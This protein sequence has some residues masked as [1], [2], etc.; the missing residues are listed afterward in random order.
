V[1]RQVFDLSPEFTGAH[2]YLALNL[3]AQRREA[4]A[5]AE[6]LCEAEAWARLL[7]LSIIHHASGHHVEADAA[8]R[9]LIARHAQDSAFQV[10][11]VYGARGETDAAF[12]WLERAYAQ[13]DPGLGS[14]KF[15]PLFR[16]LHADPRWSRFLRR[17]R[18]A[19]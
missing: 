19:D 11:E 15:Q 10:A 7:A 1:Y 16:S 5:L 13:R 18:L 12:E 3:L 17:M 14:M 6:A 9:E 4:E 8:L 2:A